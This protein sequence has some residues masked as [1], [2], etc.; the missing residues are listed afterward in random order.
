MSAA[1]KAFQFPDTTLPCSIRFAPGVYPAELILREADGMKAAPAERYSQARRE[2]LS[3]L[4]R[5]MRLVCASAVI[6]CSPGHPLH[7]AYGC[8]AAEN[9]ARV[10]RRRGQA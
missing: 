8:H 4:F 9:R 10:A 3:V 1:P 5:E 2:V 6:Q 7:S